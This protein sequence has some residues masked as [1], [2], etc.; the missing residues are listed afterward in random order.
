MGT[1]TLAG[2]LQGSPQALR[3]V[4]LYCFWSEA[5]AAHSCGPS[6]CICPFTQTKRVGDRNVSVM[7][8]GGVPSQP[9]PAI[10]KCAAAVPVVR[11]PIDAKTLLHMSKSAI[12]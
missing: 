11:L 10:R 7:P 2:G 6:A 3:G 1:A 5:T 12:T 8:A 9:G 4:N